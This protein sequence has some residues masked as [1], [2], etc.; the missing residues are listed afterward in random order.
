MISFMPG[1]LG[2]FICDPLVKRYGK[3]NVAG[4][5]FVLGIVGGIIVVKTKKNRDKKEE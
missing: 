5:P 2:I 1:I 3:K 4:I